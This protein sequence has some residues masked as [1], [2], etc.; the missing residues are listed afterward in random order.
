MARPASCTARPRA[1]KRWRRAG[2]SSTLHLMLARQRAQ[3]E[4]PLFGLPPASADRIRA[5]ARR[6][7]TLAAS[8]VSTSSAVEC[9]AHTASSRPPASALPP[10]ELPQRRRRAAHPAPHRRRA[11][12][13]ASA[14]SLGEALGV[15]HQLAL[16]GEHRLLAR[17]RREFVQLAHRVAQEIALALARS[18]LAAAIGEPGAAL[19][20]Q[21]SPGL[22]PPRRPASPSPPKASTQAPVMARGRQA[23]APR[24][25]RGSRRAGVADLAQQADAGRLV[26]DEGAAGP[27]G[28]TG[29]AEHHFALRLDALFVE[30]RQA[31]R[32]RRAASKAAVDDA[33]SAPGPH[34]AAQSPRA[35]SA[36]P[37]AS[38]RIDL[39]APVSPV[40]TVSPGPNARS[41]RSMRTMSRMERPVSM[42]GLIP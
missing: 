33:A 8:A 7:S 6:P 40:S 10:L 2:R 21:P 39:P 28:L 9:L 41:S 24:T 19:G 22:P 1:A 42:T 26:V 36:S 4:Q 14:K 11:P 30:E 27:V 12:R 5:P 20:C 17:P 3:R 25:G 32:G 29:G 16:L 35:P 18:T 37:S 34:Q 31:R 38:S 13:A 15:H 23:R